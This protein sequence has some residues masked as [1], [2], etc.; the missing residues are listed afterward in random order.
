MM[1]WS[2]CIVQTVVRRG[3]RPSTMTLLGIFRSPEAASSI[4][5]TALETTLPALAMMEAPATTMGLVT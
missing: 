4:R 2:G 5:V 1:I 3:R